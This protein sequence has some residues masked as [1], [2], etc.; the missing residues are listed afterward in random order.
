MLSRDVFIQPGTNHYLVTASCPFHRPPVITSGTFFFRSTDN[1]QT[2]E[3]GVRLDSFDGVTAQPHV[4]ADRYHVIC[5]YSGNGKDEELIKTEARTLYTQPDTWG[6]RSLVADLDTPYQTYYNGS[7][8][9]ISADGRAHTAL[10]VGNPYGEDHYLTYY[11]SSSDH[12]ASWSD[13]ELVSDDT[14]GSEYDQDIGAD[15]AGH[16]YVVWQDWRSGNG[17]IWFATNN[18]LGIAE[19]PQQQPRETEPFATIVSNALFLPEATSPKLQ[20]SSLLDIS[21]RKIMDLTPGVNDVSALAP[22]V[23]FVREERAQAQAL[24]VRKVVVTR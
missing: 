16:V 23:Y 18:P 12:G 10:M 6:S 3:P 5:D 13:R 7:K 9:A 17:R 11:A 8:L 2:F 20:A 1:G 15:S 19:Q 22:G 14:T 4:V 21:G 24:A